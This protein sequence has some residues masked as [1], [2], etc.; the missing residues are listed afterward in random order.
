MA[1]TSQQSPVGPFGISDPLQCDFAMPLRARYFPM[2]FPVEVETN[3][4]DLLSM[5]ADLWSCFPL[6]ADTPPVT[7]RVAV[8]GR[9]T[10]QPMALLPRGQAHLISIVHSPENFAV[11]DLAGAFAFAWLTQDVAADDA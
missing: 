5:T 11:A 7:F 10:V 2:G 6:L 3:S 9:S 8:C 4:T 1:V